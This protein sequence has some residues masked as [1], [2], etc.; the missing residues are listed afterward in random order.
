METM[1][2]EWGKPLTSVQEFVPQ[3]FIAACAADEDYVTYEFWCD[4]GRGEYKV[5]LDSNT[6]DQY[7]G[8]DQSITIGTTYHPC[9]ETH[10]VTVPKGTSI[11]NVFP[12]GFIRAYLD[13]G[14]GGFAYGDY[15]PVR[16]WRGNNN[17]NVHCTTQLHESQFHISNPS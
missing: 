13:L 6:N 1:K 11:D 10:S 5:W 14:I 17:D 8:G 4:A 2:K 15:I 3:E 9:Q 16:I 7:D 12:K